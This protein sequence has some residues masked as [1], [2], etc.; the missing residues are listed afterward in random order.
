MEIRSAEYY[1]S[2]E[3]RKGQNESAVIPYARWTPIFLY[4]RS[5]VVPFNF[6]CPILAINNLVCGG[7]AYQQVLRCKKMSHGSKR[8]LYDEFSLTSN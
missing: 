3:L 5:M 1:V 4:V 6:T 7:V 8:V 2:S